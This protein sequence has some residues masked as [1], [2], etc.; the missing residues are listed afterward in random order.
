MPPWE[1]H[2]QANGAKR[3]DDPKFEANAFQPKVCKNE[4]KHRTIPGSLEAG[5][6][7]SP[8]CGT[9]STVTR[10]ASSSRGRPW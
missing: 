3:L 4:Y 6:A 7:N 10:R 2:A 9:G 1:F 5:G 8:L